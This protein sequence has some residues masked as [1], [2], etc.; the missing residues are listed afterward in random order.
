MKVAPVRYFTLRTNEA[1]QLL[2]IGCVCRPSGYMLQ[3]RLD[4]QLTTES[5][6]SGW[7]LTLYSHDDQDDLIDK[8]V[9]SLRVS[10][11]F[12]YLVG[13]GYNGLSTRFTAKFKG[14]LVPREKDEHF[15]FGL[16]V[17]GKSKLYVDGKLVIDNWTRQIRGQ[18]KSFILGLH[19]WT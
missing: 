12:V 4:N 19:P 14:K 6:E 17:L 3:P 5:G 18:S 11:T 15:K 2:T 8:P 9:A 10:E 16:T 13:L 7:T 1:R